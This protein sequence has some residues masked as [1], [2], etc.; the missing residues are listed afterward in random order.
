MGATIVNVELFVEPLLRMT[1]GG[2]NSPE[3]G[4]KSADRITLPVNP[5]KLTRFIFTIVEDPAER[6]MI[7]GLA[8]TLKSGVPRDG[9]G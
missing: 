7:E 6:E 2:L 4:R 3:R 5:F 8:V 1:L 9:V